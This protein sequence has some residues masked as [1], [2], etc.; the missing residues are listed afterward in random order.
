LHPRQNPL[1]RAREV[2]GRAER[3]SKLSL[4]FGEEAERLAGEAAQCLEHA[5][6]VCARA[7]SCADEAARLLATAAGPSTP[8]RAVSHTSR[9]TILLIDDDDD[10]SATFVLTLR[11]E[12]YRVRTAVG[13][14]YDRDE[15]RTRVDAIIVDYDMPH[16]GGGLHLL[17]DLRATRYHATPVA[18]VTGDN[19][20]DKGVSRE[21]SNLGVQVWFKPICGAEL[22]KRIGL[23]M[24]V[25][26]L[27]GPSSPA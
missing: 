15:A 25:S 13:A 14:S 3:L 4:H 11:L 10:A 6:N 9:P 12:G 24:S 1:R 26:G 23:L 17:R 18:I 22:V 19:R 21:L 20:L 2:A 16:A 5:R 8:R 7:K 27:H